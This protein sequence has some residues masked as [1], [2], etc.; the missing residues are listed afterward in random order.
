MYSQICKSYAFPFLNFT[1]FNYYVFKLENRI[2]VNI[3][4]VTLYKKKI[5]IEI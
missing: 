3:F 1:F 2:S 4:T 5:L